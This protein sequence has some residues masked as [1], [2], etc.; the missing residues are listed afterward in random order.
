MTL[1]KKKVNVGSGN[2]KLADGWFY[3]D[4]DVLDITKSFDWYKFLLFFDPPTFI[5]KS[6]LKKKKDSKCSNPLKNKFRNIS[7]SECYQSGNYPYF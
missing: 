7:L 5:K 3:S 1:A 6:L 2:Y 4:I